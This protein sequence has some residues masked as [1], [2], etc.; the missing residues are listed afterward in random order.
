[1][2]WISLVAFII[3]MIILGFSIY[4]NASIYFKNKALI[5]NAAKIIVENKILKEKL[6]SMNSESNIENSNGFL[7]FVT[8]SRDWAFQ[9]IEETQLIITN[10][11]EIV[12]PVLDYYNKFGRISENPSMNKIFDAYQNLI[13]V[14]PQTE[15]NKEK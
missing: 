1:M 4:L 13:K 11:V 7:K 15:K 8:E 5:Y 9:Y 12:G 6:E 14:L 2:D 3:V 10:F